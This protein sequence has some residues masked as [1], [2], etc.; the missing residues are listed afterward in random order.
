MATLSLFQLL[1]AAI[2]TS[3]GGRVNIMQLRILLR[4]VLELTGLGDLPVPD[5]GQ[6]AQGVRAQARHVR[7]QRLEPGGWQPRTALLQGTAGNSRLYTRAAGVGQLEE[8]EDVDSSSSEV[9]ALPSPMGSTALELWPHHPL[10][11][12][13]PH[14]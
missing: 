6:A 14:S 4:A 7:Q 13:L 8:M 2:S 11:P 9:G 10:H 12:C 1:D 3:N 5:W